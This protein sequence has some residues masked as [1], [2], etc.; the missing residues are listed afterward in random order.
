MK[1]PSVTEDPSLAAKRDTTRGSLLIADDEEL[2]RRP[3]ARVFQGRGYE[4]IEAESCAHA[5]RFFRAR[6]PDLALIDY[7][8]ADGNALDLI[9]R[10]RAIDKTVPIVVLTGYARIDLAVQAIKLGAEQFFT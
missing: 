9:A 3:V 6:R 8:M 4:T 1:D 10:L 2:V 7:E 5:E